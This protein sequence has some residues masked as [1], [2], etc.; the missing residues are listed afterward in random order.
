[1]SETYWKHVNHYLPHP[2]QQQRLK[3]MISYQDLL[4]IA[5]VIIDW[6]E[7]LVVPLELNQVD[8]S[9]IHS[10]CHQSPELERLVS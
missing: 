2:N 10:K 4:K 8:I 5:E 1:M 6:E 9:D 3:E 7:K